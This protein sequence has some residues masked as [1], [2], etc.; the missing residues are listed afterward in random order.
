MPTDSPRPAP[1][2]SA[3][4]SPSSPSYPAPFDSA[5]FIFPEEW[6]ALS[7]LFG[8]ADTGL[9]FVREGIIIHLNAQLA[10][11]LG[12][13]ESELAGRPVESLFPTGNDASHPGEQRIPDA[14]A[15]ITLIGKNGSPLEFQLIENRI[16]TLTDARCTIWVLKPLKKAEAFAGIEETGYLR[17]IIEQMPDLVCVCDSETKLVFANPAFSNVAGQ[18]DEPLRD[19]VH[20]D[21]RQR[22][23]ATME[24]ASSSETAAQF[25]FMFRIR[26][27]DGAWRHIAGHARKL[28]G[29]ED[30]EGILLTAR[31]ATEQ[32]RQQQRSAADKKRMLHYL[33][34]LFRMAQRP[35]AN[36]SSALTVILKASAKAL[37][38]HRC[39]YWELD[40][41]AATPQ[42]MM[43]YD[44][45][46]QNYVDESPDPSLAESFNAM[47]QRVMRNERQ[48]VIADVDQDPRAA[49][50]CEYFHSAAIK[51]TM[52]VPVRR[53]DTV[54]GV[55]ILDHFQQPRQW[56]KDEAEFANNVAGLITL[57]FNE[58]ARGKT[59]AQLRHLAH[60][61]SLTGLPNRH[62]LFDQAA[63]FFPDVAGKANSLAAF[64]IDIDGFKNVND[65]LGHA[66][67]DELLKAAAMRLKNVVRKNDILV[68]LG[69]DEF[70]LLARNLSDMRIADDIAMQIVETMRGPFS[71]QGHELRISASVGIALYPADGTDIDTLMKKADIAMYHAKSAGRDQYQMFAPRLN[72]VAANRTA[73]EHELR[74]A[75]DQGELQHFYHPQVDLRTG[76]VRCVEALLRWRHPQHGILLPAHFL[77][78]A[79]QAG[80]I[81]DISTWVMN[82]A[83]EQLNA[84]L[85][86]G[87]DSFTLA[88]N[89][90]AS[91]LMDRALLPVLEDA[92]D[93]TGVSG[94][95][96]EWEIKESTVM[97]HN[98]MASSMLSSVGDMQIRL[99]IDDFGTGYSN[100]TYLRRYPVHKVKIDS[101]LVR[102]LPAEG[103]DR[104]VTEAI[105][106]MAQP[107]GLDVVAEGVETPQQIAYLREHG[108]HIA[109][110]FFYTQ[111][112]T[113]EQFETW[114]VRH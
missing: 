107:L 85:A 69:G 43:A 104:A 111:P 7:D 38:A 63:E 95:R 5:T 14:G 96:L 8:G 105:I 73:L 76:K 19:L 13:D 94:E 17:S 2:Q 60:H 16:D 110:G 29:N 83:C 84:W 77:P 109:Q 81:H 40:G 22:L 49:I 89:L 59:E 26:Q 97:Q 79:E 33:N 55:L 56:R 101:S 68:R 71:L 93:R 92:L 37:G 53:G 25:P 44:D 47:L 90:S 24:K 82:D 102:G 21:D 112:L 28:Q 27:P 99:S 48:L 67:G 42:C 74:R 15:H 1:P 78:L 57:V 30:V 54:S 52:M 39:A 106:S 9:L 87:L 91:Q 41:G 36:L 11:Q 10:Q 32:V 23:D 88:I 20:P 66:L 6:H 46:R 4:Y 35:H 51:A 62:Y 70:M 64:F 58:V 100:M 12:F 61:D 18:L 65:S 34:R 3:P 98:T 86:R 114:L 45:I 50:Y 108:C 103:N 31:D 72:E 75:I 80:L 113:A